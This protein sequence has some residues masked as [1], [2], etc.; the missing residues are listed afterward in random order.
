MAKIKTIFRCEAAG[1]ENNEDNGKILQLGSNKGVLLIVCDGMGGMEAGEV[2]SSLAVA[3]I[4]Q[5]FTPERIT[6]QVLTNPQDYLKQSIVGADTNI[7]NYSKTHPETE[8]MG[9]TI[10]LAWLLDQKAYVAW[11]GDSRAYRYNPQ[12][13]LERLSHDHSLVQTWV[14]AG[15]IT[16]DQAFDHP[17]SNIITRSLGDPNGV[18]MPDS[19]EYTLYNDDVILLCTD[20]LCGTLR[21]RQIEAILAGNSDLSQC[22]NQLWKTDEEAGWHDNVTT[23]LARV[24]SDGAML[25][26]AKAEPEEQQEIEIIDDE[27]EQER[28]ADKSNKLRYVVVAAICVI[29]AIVAY[30]LFKP[31]K[32]QPEKSTPA[33]EISIEVQSNTKTEKEE[34]Q[35]EKPTTTLEEQNDNPAVS[36]N[37]T[38]N[39]TNETEKK[40][41]VT[42]DEQK[43][44][45]IKEEQTSTNEKQPLDP[46]TLPVKEN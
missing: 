4:E 13:G 19:A 1:R 10:V 16:E 34:T 17:Q 7:K 37:V 15:Q 36:V 11:C 26:M 28:P 6:K 3:T 23:A 5:W 18:A 39:V 14:D 31:A 29:V 42:A 12:L 22:C 38:I 46:K 25:S 35:N 9:S 33:T 2:A 45:E 44:E 30:I 27:P 8:G 21:D 41:D 32:N 43:T 40:E 24:M 20:G